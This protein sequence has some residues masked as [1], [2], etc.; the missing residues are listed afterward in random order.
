M[1]DTNIPKPV[2][3]V[4]PS[5]KTS[6]SEQSFEAEDLSAEDPEGQDDSA[7]DEDEASS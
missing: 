1:P 4:D 6:D 2:T 7:L 3:Q 5:E